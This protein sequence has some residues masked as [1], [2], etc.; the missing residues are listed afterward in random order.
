LFQV[1]INHI[2]DRAIDFLRYTYDTEA[3]IL[4]EAAPPQAQDSGA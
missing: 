3:F 4:N 1:Q 2:R